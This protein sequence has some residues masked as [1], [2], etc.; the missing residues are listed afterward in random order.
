[1]KKFLLLFLVILPICIIFIL[2]FISAYTFV[3]PIKYKNGIL[4]RSDAR[5]NGFFGSERNGNRFHEGVDLLADIGTPV[6][7]A[8]SG[9]VRAAKRV[10]GMGKFVIIQHARGVSTLYGHLAEIYVHKRQFVRQGQVIGQVGKTGNANY[11]SI[12]P[13]LHFEVLKDRVPQDP[14]DYLQ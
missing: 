6:L 12:Q 9:R 4:I 14:L 1:M 10:K 3:C 8:A 2:Y 7:A 13:H 11:R 5:G